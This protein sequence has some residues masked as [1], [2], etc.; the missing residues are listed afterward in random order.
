VYGARAVL[1]EI[2]ETYSA[3][4]VI[5]H[6]VWVLMVEGDSESEVKEAARQFD[7]AQVH[8]YFD[9]E[10]SVGLAYYRDVFPNCVNEL[11][12]VTP[13]EHPM[14]ASLEEWNDSKE[15][16]PVWDAVFYY[17]A[18]VRWAE[19]VP[20]PQRWSKQVGFFGGAP[21]EAEVPAADGAAT[22][23]Q[24]RITG[25]FFRNDCAHPPAESD[26]YLEVREAARHLLR[27]EKQSGQGE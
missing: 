2:V 3:D 7:G 17:P 24:T 6:I 5:V 1:K 18:G 22:E 12:A 16:R 26:W 25:L 4:A 9:K 21:A 10:T 13:K 19:K 23:P 11:L 15:P 27:Q 20:A 8:Q 14:Y